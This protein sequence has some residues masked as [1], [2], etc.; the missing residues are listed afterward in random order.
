[1]IAKKQSCSLLDI[2]SILYPN[3]SWKHVNQKNIGILLD[4]L[5]RWECID[6]STRTGKMN[7]AAGS[8]FDDKAGA[9]YDT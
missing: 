6:R 3:R 7:G 5:H 1:M 9:A 8:V 4:Q 2:N